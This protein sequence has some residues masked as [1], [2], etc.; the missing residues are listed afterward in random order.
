LCSTLPALAQ[1]RHELVL[2][3]AGLARINETTR[4]ARQQAEPAL[5]QGQKRR[6]AVRRDIAA[7]KIRLNNTPARA[8]KFDLRKAT[9]RHRR[10]LASDLV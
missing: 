4:Q 8:W 10:I 9:I 1:Q 5:R 7:G 3:L 2:D 6:P